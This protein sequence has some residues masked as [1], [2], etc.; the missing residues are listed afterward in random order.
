MKKMQPTLAA[1]R[2]YAVEKEKFVP[3][4]QYF[5]EDTFSLAVI[6]EKLPREVFR[7]LMQ[8]MNESKSLDEETANVVAHAMKEWA[9]EKG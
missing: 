8:A 2:Q 7:K 1:E 9:I 4:S 5:G 3:V 6:K